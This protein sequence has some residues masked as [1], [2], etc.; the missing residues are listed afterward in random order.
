MPT[1]P[2]SANINNVVS[3]PSMRRVRQ[4]RFLQFRPYRL[5]DA[6]E[7]LKYLIIPESNDAVTALLE[8]SRPSRIKRHFCIFSMLSAIELNDQSRLGAAE[9]D[10]IGAFGNLPLEF[11]SVYLAIAQARP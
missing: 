9:I 3:Q 10:D 1:N 4:R 5:H 2:P 11:P 8:K 7:I 6:I